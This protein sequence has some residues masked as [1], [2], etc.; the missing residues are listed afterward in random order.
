MTRRAV[1]LFRCLG[2]GLPNWCAASI[3][4]LNRTMSKLTGTEMVLLSPGTPL[5]SRLLSLWAGADLHPAH[6]ERQLEFA[7]THID[8]PPKEMKIQDISFTSLFSANSFYTQNE[9]RYFSVKHEYGYPN[10]S[11]QD[12]DTHGKPVKKASGNFLH[13]F[14][15]SFSNT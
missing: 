10:I 5:S 9:I 1:L 6:R 4:K 15:H 2:S 12:Q 14:P 11:M 7:A 3:R 8:S 13:K